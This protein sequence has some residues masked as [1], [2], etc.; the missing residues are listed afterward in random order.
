[1]RKNISAIFIVAILLSSFGLVSCK[2]YLD[3]SPEANIL[4]TEPFINF[5]NFQGFTEELYC[6]LPDMSHPNWTGDWNWGDDIV[7]STTALQ[8]LS[9]QFDVGNYWAWQ[10]GDSWLDERSGGVSVANTAN[11]DA[12]NKGLWPLS[13]YGIRK[14]NMGLANLGHFVDGTQEEKDVIKGQLLFFRGFFHFQLMSFWGGLPYIDTLLSGSQRFEL[15]RL[16]YRQ[17]ALLAAKDLEAAAA[18]LPA[19]WNKT[20]VGQATLNHNNGR[21]TK[22]A[23]LAYLG[24]TLLYAASPLMNEE[25]TGNGA[26]DAEL[27]KKAAE[28]FTKVLQLSESGEAYYQLMPFAT[29][30][31]IWYSTTNPVKHPGFP[32]VIWGPPTY[33]RGNTP[34]GLARQFVP[35]TIGG[36]LGVEAPTANYINNFGMANGL[37]IEDP[38]SGYTTA[39]PWVNRDPRFYKAIITDG[40]RMIQ[41]SGGVDAY[42]FA[43]LYTGGNY[44]SV[45]GASRTGYLTRKFTTAGNNDTDKDWDR[46]AITMPYLR[47]AD[48]YLMYAEAV[49]H[50]YGTPQSAYPGY[51][52][53]ALDAVNLIRARATVPPIDPK[54]LT[55]KESFME[56][57]IRERAVELAYEGF[58]WMDLRRWKLAGDSRFLSKT[59]AE[60]DRGPNNKPLNYREQL[61]HVRVFQKKHEWLPLPVDQVSLY[62][63]FGQNPGW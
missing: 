48:V 22:S 12:K 15:P 33:D 42:R 53:T 61:I 5:R 10:S 16:N 44:R 47:L 28:A 26:Y 43:N 62:P 59:S 32:E 17:T 56:Q 55:S 20:T 29:Y 30:G 35:S 34:F 4:E 13:W 41:G 18:L 14:A 1:M 46:M 25:S 52:L 63:G 8:R 7:P 3:R 11:N 51:S 39:D 19:D 9:H 2:K 60:F 31:N 57:L 58:R 50:G 38:A 54:F 24:K 36:D 27:C 37:P 6:A 40:T 45:S 21:V 49:L 23:A